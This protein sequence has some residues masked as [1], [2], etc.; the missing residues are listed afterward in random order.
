MCDIAAIL[1][2]PQERP[3][4]IWQEIR[5][6]FAENLLFNEERG[7]EAAGIGILKQNGDASVYKAP[8]PARQLVQ[9]P[10]YRQLI[11]GLDAQ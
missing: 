1:L 5:H 4:S 6:C 2:Q 10:S 3:P 11:G 7:K 9:Q 8:L